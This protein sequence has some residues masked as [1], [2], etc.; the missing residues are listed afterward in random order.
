MAVISITQLLDLRLPL[1]D[2]F[3]GLGNDLAGPLASPR[4]LMWIMAFAVA[5]DSL[6]A[7]MRTPLDVAFV[8]MRFA[9][10]GAAIGTSRCH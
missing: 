7:A 10:R 3:F 6:A 8:S 2:E 9:N 1:L 4:S 5:A